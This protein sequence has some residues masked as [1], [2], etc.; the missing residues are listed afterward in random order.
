MRSC[1]DLLVKG[2]GNFNIYD[3]NDA[4]TL[5]SADKAEANTNTSAKSQECGFV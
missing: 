2:I 5:F 1:P 3:T 4:H